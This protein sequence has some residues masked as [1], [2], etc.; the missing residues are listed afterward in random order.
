MTARVRKGAVSFLIMVTTTMI[1]MFG[2]T[3]IAQA[4][5]TENHSNKYFTQ[6]LAIG[7]ALSK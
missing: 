3:A 2:S 7:S 6:E 1:L 4:P 5:D